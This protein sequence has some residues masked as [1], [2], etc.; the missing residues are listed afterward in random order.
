[1]TNTCKKKGGVA[2]K[3]IEI[4]KLLLYLPEILTKIR[5]TR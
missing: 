2:K 3:K 5:E 4:L 1:M